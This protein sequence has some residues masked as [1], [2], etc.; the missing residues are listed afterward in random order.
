MIQQ[1]YWNLSP[2]TPGHLRI[3]GTGFWMYNYIPPCW[4]W[5]PLSREV[6]S[7]ALEQF[8]RTVCPVQDEN[9]HIED[10]Q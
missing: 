4:Q 5:P 8:A 1:T 10:G 2:L 3:S 7:K 6:G 9:P